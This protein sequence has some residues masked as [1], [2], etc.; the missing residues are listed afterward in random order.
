MPSA[1]KLDIDTRALLPVA[2]GQ[3]LRRIVEDLHTLHPRLCLIALNQH[4]GAPYQLARDVRLF[5]GLKRT[6]IQD[7]KSPNHKNETVI[8]ECELV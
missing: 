1:H 4:S 5:G 3:G 8:H 6:S 2:A 7:L